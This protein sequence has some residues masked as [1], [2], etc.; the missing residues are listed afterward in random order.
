MSKTPKKNTVR[1]S[2]KAKQPSILEI[3]K[4][5]LS[6]YQN[7]YGIV[8]HEAN[9][10]NRYFTLDTFAEGCVTQFVI[11][12]TSAFLYAQNFGCLEVKLGQYRCLMVPGAG[13]NGSGGLVL[14][15][16]DG[17]I[18][19]EMTGPE[20]T[21]FL[22]NIMT[23]GSYSEA[24]VSANVLAYA[25]NSE[26]L[27]K[28][29]DDWKNY[30]YVAKRLECDTNKGRT[31]ITKPSEFLNVV[32]SL[33]YQRYPDR[34]VVSLHDLS[35]EFGRREIKDP[36]IEHYHKLIAEGDMVAREHVNEPLFQAPVEPDVKIV[37]EYDPAL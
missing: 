23:F 34:E 10:H 22:N 28:Y 18:N 21:K 35:I 15:L 6:L 30:D 27:S 36:A 4:K 11:V 37:K 33:M 13:P 3:I 2:K 8:G 32:Q 7:D 24:A 25:L 1:R 5:S 26:V 17:S 14:V 12:P 29:M 9:K 31:L 20:T 19:R 16:E